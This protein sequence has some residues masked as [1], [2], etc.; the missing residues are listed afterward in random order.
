M[1][2]ARNMLFKDIDS[3]DNLSNYVAMAM[4]QYADGNAEMGGP[5]HTGSEGSRD[6]GSR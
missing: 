6:R 1:N 2:Y 5:D 4:K 3:P